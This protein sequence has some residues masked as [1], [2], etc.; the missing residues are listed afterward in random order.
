[1]LKLLALF[2]GVV[3]ISSASHRLLSVVPRQTAPLQ[4]YVGATNVAS[5]TLP[6]RAGLEPT[7]PFSS[8]FLKQMLLSASLRNS[9]GTHGV[10]HLFQRWQDT[11]S[12]ENSKSFTMRCRKLFVQKAVPLARY[13]WGQ[14]MLLSWWHKVFLSCLPC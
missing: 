7:P 2:Q 12:G 3:L 11:P 9:G 6:V 10:L 4:I 8:R 1:M 13:A 5:S 14:S